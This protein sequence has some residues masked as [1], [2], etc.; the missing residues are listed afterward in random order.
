MKIS[1]LSIAASAAL[2]TTL[3]C[4]L[5]SVAQAGGQGY[6]KEVLPESTASTDLGL[7]NFSDNPFH[8][9]VTARG[10][11][12]DNVN[13]APF[14]EQESA[15][16]NL[17]LGIT[18]NFGDPRTTMSLDSGAGGTYY[19]NRD[20]D[21]DVNAYIRFSVSHKVTPR[22]TLGANLYL[23]Y[24]SQPDFQNFA[25]GA[26]SFGRQNQNFFFSVD[27]FYSTFA[28]TPRFSTLSSFTVGYTDYDSEIRSLFED[29]VELTSGTEFRFLA[30]PTTTVV[31]EY[32]IGNVIYS[33]VD[34]RDSNSLFLLA[35]FDHDFSPR[36]SVSMRGGVEFREYDNDNG[37]L[38][39]G[40]D[41]NEITSPYGELTL[42]YAI[43]E[44]TKVSWFNRYSIE[45]P[46]LP[47]VRSRQTYRTSL[48]LTHNF[49]PRITGGL[50]AAYQNDDYDG[51]AIA[52]G[53]TEDSFDIAVSV[54][55][56]INRNWAVDLGYNH[57]EVV[58]DFM[59][60]E[61]AR[62]RVYGGVAFT[63]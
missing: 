52:T 50:S 31:L 8:V 30:A 34:D 18:Y 63:F 27:K 51:N 40:M 22:W 15:F 35:G 23:S 54:R 47:Q 25:A 42:N 32:R 2:V 60:R 19:F 14:D 45:E 9:T 39:L 5:P 3:L 33:E 36:F 48:S 44:T 59:F 21:F 61:Y 11:Y 37:A 55:Y 7:G 53:F 13:L 10:G 41:E 38:F 49:T 57:T 1:N 26:T 6:T 28:W 12:D 46:G 24:Q 29:R 58:S 16:T 43:A 56:A 4:L 17:A 20:D 62:N